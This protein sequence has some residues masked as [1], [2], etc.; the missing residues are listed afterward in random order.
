MNGRLDKIDQKSALTRRLTFKITGLARLL[1]KVR[2]DRR[3]RGMNMMETKPEDFAHR[4]DCQG[5]TIDTVCLGC[6]MAERDEFDTI[7]DAKQSEICELNNMIEAA[8]T[9]CEDKMPPDSTRVLCFVKSRG[10]QILRLHTSPLDSYRPGRD[11]V[12][13]SVSCIVRRFELRDV[14]HWMPI[15]KTPNAELR[16]RPL[17]DGP[18]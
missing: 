2:V 10:V 18:A 15:P 3:V 13:D 5:A 6:E 12:G 4:K 11:W 7:L 1:R 14:T 8:W 9:S 16:G 17:A